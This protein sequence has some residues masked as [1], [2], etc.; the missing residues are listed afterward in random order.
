MENLKISSIDDPALIPHQGPVRQP[1]LKLASIV[2]S[3]R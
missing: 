1:I 2:F 3:T